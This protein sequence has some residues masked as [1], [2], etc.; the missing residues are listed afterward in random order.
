MSKTKLNEKRDNRKKK[1]LEKK[2]V[3]LLNYLWHL[4][5]NNHG[6]RLKIILTY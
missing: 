6:I 5:I 1:S 2:W 3:N 4:D